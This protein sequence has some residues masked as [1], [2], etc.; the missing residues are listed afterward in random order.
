MSNEI[1]QKILDVAR[2][3]IGQKE[4][5]GNIFKDDTE[6]G[7]KLH[8]AGQKDGDPWCALFCEVVFKE[9]FPERFKELDVLFSSS[10]VKTFKNFRDAAYSIGELPSVGWL[11]VWRKYV[12]G[13]P[14]W[15]GHIGIVSKVN[16][17]GTFESIEG[18][19][20]TEGSREGIEV[21]ERPHRLNKDVN[22]GLRVIG[23]V[24]VS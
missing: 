20:N 21:A 15:Q 5:T 24:K 16:A 12:K 3:Y 7:A 19:T 10:A 14:E 4:L 23:F 18:N 1:N 13:Q 8:A 2:K 22:D 6:L 11:V 9:A 17:D